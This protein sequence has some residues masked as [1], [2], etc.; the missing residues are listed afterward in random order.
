MIIIVGV[1]YNKWRGG[2][3][4]YGKIK[5]WRNNGKIFRKYY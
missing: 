2:G 4:Y 1:K 3:I 5:D